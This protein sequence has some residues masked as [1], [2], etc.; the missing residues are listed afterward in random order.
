VTNHDLSLEVSDSCNPKVFRVFDTSRYCDAEVENYL[1]EIL[2]PQKSSFVPFFVQKGFSL[3]ANS[4]SLKYRKV[5]D[6]DELRA[7]PDGIYEIKQSYKPNLQTMAHF[8]HLRTVDLRLKIKREW[9]KLLSDEC[10]LSR[11]EFY[12]NRDKLREIE[13][14]T[15]A[16][17][18][19]IEECHDKKRGKEMYEWSLKL[20]E[21][22][23]NECQC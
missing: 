2:P 22:Y 3:A 12:L 23:S 16:A 15:A 14:Y 6:V 20:L 7:L 11:E 18:Y 8:Y 9:K 4:S 13:E 17:K 21:Q 19:S 10:K 5:N 1:L